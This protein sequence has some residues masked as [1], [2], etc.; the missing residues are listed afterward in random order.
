MSDPAERQWLRTVLVFVLVLAG[1]GVFAV[2]L[3]RAER[4]RAASDE[5]PVLARIRTSSGTVVTG[6]LLPM[7]DCPEGRVCANPDDYQ[8]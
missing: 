6:T 8:E 5:V 7:P 2:W 3:D 4:T 1:I